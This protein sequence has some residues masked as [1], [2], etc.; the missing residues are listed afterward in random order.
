MEASCDIIFDGGACNIFFVNFGLYYSGQKPLKD[1]FTPVQ[2]NFKPKVC[3]KPLRVD[4]SYTLWC[5]FIL[6]RKYLL[7]RVNLLVFGF[8]PSLSASADFVFSII[9][10]DW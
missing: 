7:N 9:L 3:M 5:V 8:T 10:K 6:D 2:P 4:I 1:E